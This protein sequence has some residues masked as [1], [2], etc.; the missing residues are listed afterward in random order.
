MEDCGRAM[1]PRLARSQDAL[2]DKFA[3]SRR[4]RHVRCV[5]KPRHGQA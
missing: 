3:F 1:N 4:T 2:Y 5:R